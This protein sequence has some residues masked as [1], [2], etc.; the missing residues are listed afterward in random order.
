MFL[1]VVLMALLSVLIVLTRAAVLFQTMKGYGQYGLGGP[2]ETVHVMG[3]AEG[4]HLFPR[5]SSPRKYEAV[6]IGCD[7][8]CGGGQCGCPCAIL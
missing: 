7:G 3:D 1:K 6:C 4:R 2:G 5:D 8:C